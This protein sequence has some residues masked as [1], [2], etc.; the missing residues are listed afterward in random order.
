M[1]LRFPSP[2]SHSGYLTRSQES[3]QL[4]AILDLKFQIRVPQMYSHGIR[5]EAKIRCYRI[6]RKS[7]GQAIKNLMFACSQFGA[8]LAIEIAVALRGGK[9]HPQSGSLQD[10]T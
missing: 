10:I 6:C 8:Q 9:L 4:R 2:S 7:L 1:L 3:L 5:A